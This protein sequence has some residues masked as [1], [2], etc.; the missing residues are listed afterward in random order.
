[1]LNFAPLVI[2]QRSLVVLFLSVA[3]EVL[4]CSGPVQRTD[5]LLASRITEALLASDELNLSRI[6]VT[7]E[8]GCVYLSGMSDDYESKVHAE[9]IARRVESVKEVFN[10][11]EVDF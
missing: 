4:G 3:M 10:K 9:N 8:R 5:D 6:E 1:M 11:I 2:L 7:V